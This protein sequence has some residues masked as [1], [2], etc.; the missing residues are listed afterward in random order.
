[1]AFGCAFKTF[2]NDKYWS[3]TMEQFREEYCCYIGR[4]SEPGHYNDNMWCVDPDQTIEVMRNVQAAWIAFKVLAAGAIHPKIGFPFA[5]RNGADFIVVGM[6]DFQVKQN[7]QLAKQVLAK[8]DR[9]ERPW[10][11]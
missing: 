2:H 1:M 7:A 5:L 9:R 11:A 3:V 4:S 10:C 8:L 6:F